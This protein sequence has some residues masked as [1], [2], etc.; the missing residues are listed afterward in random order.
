MNVVFYNS[1]KIK[2]KIITSQKYRGVQ[3]RRN[4]KILGR[5]EATNYE[6][7]SATMVV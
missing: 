5:G 7:L 4:E 3:A 1:K 2:N 6:I